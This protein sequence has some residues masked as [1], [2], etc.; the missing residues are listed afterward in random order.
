MPYEVELK[1]AQE[2]DSNL[3][4]KL[5]EWGATNKKTEHQVDIYFQHP[6]RDFSQTDEAMRIRSVGTRNVLTYKGP[7]IDS[8]TKTRLE[9]EVEFESG[10]AG[11][12]TMCLIL[13]SNGYRKVICV[14]KLRESYRLDWRSRSFEIAFDTV[15]SLGKFIEIETIAEEH[16]RPEATDSIRQ[17]AK[18]FGLSRQERRGY[19]RLLLEQQGE[20]S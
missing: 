9:Q 15:E 18:E 8:E 6:A 7:L 2:P 12:E 4:S 11:R 13:E 14:E 16:D 1:F 20:Q 17:L 5:I 10:D 19:L 3:E